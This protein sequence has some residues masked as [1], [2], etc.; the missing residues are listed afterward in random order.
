MRF[1]LAGGGTGGHVNP[2]LALAE[3]LRSE[4]HEVIALGTEE[5]LEQRLVPERGFE[6]VTIPRLPLPRRLSP[7]VLA[8]PLRLLAASFKVRSLIRERN[9]DAV[10]GFGGYASAPAYLGAWFAKVPLVIHEANAIAGFA[11]R[12]GARLTKHR[13]IAFPNS[14]LA[15]GTLTGM[16]IRKELVEGALS[17]DSGQARVEL[18]LDPLLPTL[19]V[20]GGSQGAKSINEAVIAALPDFNNAGIQVLHIVGEK[21]GLEELNTS[22]YLR[23]AYCDRMDAAIAASDLAISRAGASTVSEFA[24]AG[25]PAVF[26]P[27]PVGNGEQRHNATSVIDAGGAEL[28][29]DRAF[30]AEYI[31]ERVIPILSHKATLKKMSDAARSTGIHDAAERLRDMLYSAVDTGSHD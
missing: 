22:G 11:N 6:L 23:L 29:E 1:L 27:Y 21:A 19:L 10:V 13:A 8:F 20:T 5:G 30:N 24:A 9:V 7:S 28:C 25:L 3:L 18:G 31:A 17:Y 26:V 4:G 16:P 14:N 15:G 12:L 2:L